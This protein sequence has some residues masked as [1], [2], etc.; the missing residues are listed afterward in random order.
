MRLLKLAF[1][2]IHE[3]SLSV[4]TSEEVRKYLFDSSGKQIRNLPKNFKF[5]GGLYLS[6]TQITSLPEVVYMGLILLLEFSIRMNM[7]K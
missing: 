1:D 4:T 3:E 7:M 2:D 6:Y 5:S